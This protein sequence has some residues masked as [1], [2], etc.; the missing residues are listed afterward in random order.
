MARIDRRTR[1]LVRA[2]YCVFDKRPPCY[3]NR[4]PEL[5]YQQ[6]AMQVL[7]R[8]GRALARPVVPQGASF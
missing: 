7:E 8:R 2:V 6:A 3:D 5:S 1:R 4:L